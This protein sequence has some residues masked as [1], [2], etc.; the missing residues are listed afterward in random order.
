MSA[1]NYL[2]KELLDH[3][4]SAAAYSAPATLYLGLTADIMDDTD[5]GSTVTEPGGGSYAR[6][7]ITNNATNF[8][9]ATGTTTATKSNGAEFA[10]PQATADWFT[11]GGG[12]AQYWFLADA[13]TG[14]NII[15]YGPLD[16]PTPVL[17]NDTF[18]LPAGNLTN[19]L[20]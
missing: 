5:T 6:V 13:P 16:T 2:A 3:V 18:T 8:P 14:G 10:F 12:E 4:L 9:A 11:A 19:T 1:S 15:V 20:T 17:N 7:A